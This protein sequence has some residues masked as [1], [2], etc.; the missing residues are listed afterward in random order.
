M[1]RL[2]RLLP[3]LALALGALALA[4]PATATPSADGAPSTDGYTWSNSVGTGDIGTNGYT[5]SN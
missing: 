3:V 2:S 1:T 4:P 5:W